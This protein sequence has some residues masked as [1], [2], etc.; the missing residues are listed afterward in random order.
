M[1]FSKL[2]FP[3]LICCGALFFFFPQLDIKFS[4]F[5]YHPQN[6]FYLKD[7]AFCIFIYRSVEI[8]ALGLAAGLPLLLF[9]SAVLKNVF[10]SEFRKRVLYLILTLALG[11]GLLVNVIFKEHWGRARPD[12]IEQFGGS[13]RFTPA[14]VISS[15][16]KRNCAFV[17][18]H[19]SVGF[20]LISAAFL[21]KKHRKKGLVLAISYGFIIG[22]VRIIQGSHFASDVIFSFYFVYIVSK[23]GYKLMFERTPSPA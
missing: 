7:Y 12:H 3:G 17:S 19:A 22:L 2:F 9:I 8:I 11:P 14:F 16:C 10:T 1:G 23:G 6:R 4:S 13:N 5:F 18:G 15:E 21:M 20:Y